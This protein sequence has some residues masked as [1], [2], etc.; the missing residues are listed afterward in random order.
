M[1]PL[2]ALSTIPHKYVT[3]TDLT[4]TISQ[5]EKVEKRKN[6]QTFSFTV[7]RFFP[8]RAHQNVFDNMEPM[9]SA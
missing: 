7:S 5:E 3:L 9:Q 2:L 6:R 4:E 8:L 1:D